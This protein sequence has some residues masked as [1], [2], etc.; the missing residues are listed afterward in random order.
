MQDSKDNQRFFL[1]D[2]QNEIVELAKKVNNKLSPFVM[3]ESA[4]EGGGRLERPTRNYPI[5]FFCRAANMADGGD[6]AVAKEKAWMH[7]RNFLS[8]LKAKHD[9]EIGRNIDGD[10]A[11]ID[12]DSAFLDIMTTGPIG[13][14]WYGVLIQ[15]D[16][17]EPL[18]LCVDP[19][20]YLPEVS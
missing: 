7:A 4:V 2:S 13:N 10:F 11:R 14:G 9:E 3:M 1:A 6:A 16:R 5:Y 8:W 20:L 18:N 19:E 12:L 15:L 17:E